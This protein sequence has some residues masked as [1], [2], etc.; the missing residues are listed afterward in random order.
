MMMFDKLT[1]TDKKMIKLYIEKNVGSLK[2]SLD[3]ILKPWDEAKSESYLSTLF[4]DTLIFKEE[5]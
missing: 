5:V 1:E 4:K 2:T 3:F